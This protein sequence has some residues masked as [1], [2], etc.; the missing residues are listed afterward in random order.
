MNITKGQKKKKTDK[1]R[2][3][4][5]KTDFTGKKQ[6]KEDRKRMR[7]IRLTVAYDG[8]DYCG[9]QVQNNVA[10]IEGEL[11]TALT[12]LTGQTVKV[13]GASRTDAGVHARGNV[14]VDRK[15]VV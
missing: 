15:S 10:T 11:N 14:A 7:R 9:W 5:K 8:T 12:R 6:K 2:Q 3:K 4:R 1:N 13:I